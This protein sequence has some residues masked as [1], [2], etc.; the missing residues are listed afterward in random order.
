MFYYIN[1]MEVL[2]I[3]NGV[4]SS[5]I[6]YNHT[7]KKKKKKKKKTS[8]NGARVRYDKAKD[9]RGE[10]KSSLKSKRKP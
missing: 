8:P 6:I 9:Q 4:R 7:H 10:N 2:R 5:S 3:N 1:M